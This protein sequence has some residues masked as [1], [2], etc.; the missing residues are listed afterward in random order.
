[1]P[2][3]FAL[4]ALALTFSIV[5]LAQ[6]PAG[7]SV[8]VLGGEY[9]VATCPKLN[10][11]SP[12]TMSLADAMRAESGPCRVCAPNDHDPA[13][14]TFVVN[15]AVAI[16]RE[17][18]PARRAA[19]A[20]ERK[21][22]E[23][24]PFVRVTASQAEAI[25]A[26]AVG[27]AKND[28]D[29]F[30]KTFLA[31]IAKTAPEFSLLAGVISNSDALSINIAGPLGVFLSSA[32]ERVRKFEPLTPPPVWSPAIHVIVS[33]SR[34]DAPDI[35]KIIV[36]RN[37]SI[38]V[39]LG[40]TLAPHE[41]VTASGA[42]RMIHSGVVTYALSAFEPGPDVTVTVIA[43]PESGTNITRTFDSI[44]LRAIQ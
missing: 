36:Q 41:L 24:D 16:S 35:E 8:L 22:K 14:K 38:V 2:S 20:A 39:A 23:G 42:K 30:R 37:G 11:Q 3:R 31:A 34:I 44:E 33:P 4:V 28:S 17:L 27:Q 1:M 18:E 15:Y 6:V 43:I 32:S 29:A 5:V 12:T 19:A 7:P 40:S 13:I 10:G 21:R 9:H 25:S 26:D